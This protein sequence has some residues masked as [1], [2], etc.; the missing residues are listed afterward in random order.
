MIRAAAYLARSA[1]SAMIPWKTCA[2]AFVLFFALGLPRSTVAQC[3]EEPTVLMDERTAESH[4][5]AKKDL[6]LPADVPELAKVRTVV[7]LVT[8][9]REGDVCEVK[10]VLGTKALQETA[11][12]IVKEHWRY[13]R[14]L[15]DGKP[16]VAQF[17]VT[18]RFMLPKNEPRL[19]A[20]QRARTRPSGQRKTV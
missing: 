6:V 16:V 17:P 14:F 3:S 2:S 8:V 15:L 18:V 11:V 12:R 10:P 19:T 5:L 20:V 9:D 1:R 7:L 4:L 13:R